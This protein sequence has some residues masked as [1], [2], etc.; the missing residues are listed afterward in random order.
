MTTATNIDPKTVDQVRTVMKQAAE[1]WMLWLIE[2]RRHEVI[3]TIIRAQADD[4][5]YDDIPKLAAAA[6][7]AALAIYPAPT[8]SEAAPAAPAAPAGGADAG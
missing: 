2:R 3:M 5:D 8:A 6:A 7:T 1:V 4:T